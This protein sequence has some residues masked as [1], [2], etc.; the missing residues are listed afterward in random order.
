MRKM[1]FL[2]FLLAII[3]PSSFAEDC[4]QTQ[5][6]MNKCAGSSYQIADNELN[7][8]YKTQMDYLADSLTK[9]RLKAA[10]LNWIKFR[11]AACLYE[12]GE[13]SDGGSSWS[14]KQDFC[15]ERLT[16]ARIADLKYYV[17]CRDNGC[18][19]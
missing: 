1:K 9:D 16:K 7:S 2:V 15:L 4:G 8:L 10:Q 19:Y 13:R 3:S 14:M 18:P 12:V 5:L 11:D 17:D 6:E